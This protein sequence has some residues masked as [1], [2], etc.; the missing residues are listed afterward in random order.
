MRYIR[1]LEWAAEGDGIRFDMLGDDQETHRFEVSTECAG[2][3]VGALAAESEKFNAEGKDQQFIRPTGMQT[4]K[5]AEGEP[6][7]LMTL[8]GGTELPLVFKAEALNVLVRELEGL[9]R[10]L[11][12]GSQVRWR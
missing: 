10:S 1:V 3:L 7:I 6:V 4:A 5:T 12:P 9:Q 2:S 11:D 8:K